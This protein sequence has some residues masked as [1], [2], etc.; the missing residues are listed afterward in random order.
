VGI[1]SSL[2]KR[3]NITVER[4]KLGDFTYEI[5]EKAF[6]N[7][8]D[9]LDWS[10]SN[11]VLMTV[12]A[13]RAKLYSQMQIT[14]C[15]SKGDPI[16][17]SDVLKLLKN[18]NYFQSQQDF[19][20]QQMWYLSATGENFTYSPKRFT[21]ELP[22]NLYNL[23][24]SCLDFDNTQEL[25]KF[26]KSKKD[27]KAFTDQA[28][29]YT[30][31]NE[32]LNIKIADLIPFYD[33]ANN[34]QPNNWMNSPSR[35]DGI[36][37]VLE[38]IEENIKAK[39]VNLKM[40][41]KFLA[42]N[43]SSAEGTPMIQPQDRTDIESKIGRKSLLVT[44]ANVDVKHLVSDM[45]RLYLDEQLSNDAMSVLLAFEMNK[46]VLNY[47]GTSGSTYENQ[48]QGIIRFIQNSIQSSADNTMNSFSESFGLFEKNEMLKASFN[49]LP[50]MQ[51]VM[52]TK[53]ETFKA[54]QEAL[55]ISIESG[56]VTQ[57]EAKEM[58]DKLR[59]DLGL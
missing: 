34:I 28:I 44:N 54:Y 22:T 43:K 49:H 19:L 40:A 17:N 1:F 20:F 57:A 53:I 4:N 59:K 52:L 2:F 29:K 50:V 23:I 38:N 8:K 51:V 26:L 25:D 47:L 48:E 46:D 5:S 15:D 9:Y 37:N 27:V 58:S 6:G 14:H 36:A 33:L 7:D 16:E 55:K 11:P 42:S 12:I 31:N 32:E 30:L 18:P 41:Q 39:N 21:T 13:L 35:V 45:K 56:T 24:P 3:N 10:L